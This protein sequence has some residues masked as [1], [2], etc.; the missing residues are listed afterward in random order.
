M[1]V[2][3]GVSAEHISDRAVGYGIPGLLVDGMDVLA[4]YRAVREAV[5]HARSGAGPV[6]LDVVTYRYV[7]P[8]QERQAGLSLAGRGQAVEAAGSHFELRRPG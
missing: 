1:P 4:V 2:G 3:R 7:G 5:A 8:F 6:L